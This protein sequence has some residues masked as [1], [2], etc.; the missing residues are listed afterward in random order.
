MSHLFYKIELIHKSPK[1]MIEIIEHIRYICVLFLIDVDA[2]LD[3]VWKKVMIEVG[4]SF[5]VHSK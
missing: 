3:M 2:P 1:V 5:D 4:G